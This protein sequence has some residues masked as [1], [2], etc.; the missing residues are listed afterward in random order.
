MRSDRFPES[1]LILN[2]TVS[3]I[4]TNTLIKLYHSCEIKYRRTLNKSYTFFVSVSAKSK[5]SL[6]AVPFINYKG[7]S[8]RFADCVVIICDDDVQ[9]VQ[10]LGDMNVLKAGLSRNFFPC[11]EIVTISNA[12]KH[13]RG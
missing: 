11:V 2:H 10:Y 4:D 5:G 1:S 8:T 12:L 6:A 7:V 9:D 13:V 3:R